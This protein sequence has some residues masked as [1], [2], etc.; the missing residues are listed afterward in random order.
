MKAAICDRPGCQSLAPFNPPNPTIASRAPGGQRDG[1]VSKLAL[2]ELCD[3]C[4]KSLDQ[5]WQEKVEMS[6]PEVK[7]VTA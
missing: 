1:K 6:P 2:R 7:E 3:P 4:A 5:W